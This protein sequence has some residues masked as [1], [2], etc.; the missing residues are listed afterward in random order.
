MVATIFENIY[1]KKPH[2][3]SVPV[4]LERIRNG[5]SRD[6]I[7]AI[8]GTID[9]EKAD[10]LKRLLPSVCFSGKFSK[11]REDESLIAHSGFIVLDFD[12]VSDLREKQ[13]ELINVPYVYACWV[14][15]R[16]NGL[17]ALLK[18]ADGT[19]HRE[20]FAA[21][22][23]LFPDA[24]KSGV[25]LS[26]VCYESYDPEIY[27]N[28]GAE[29]FTA[30][31]EVEQIEVRETIRETRVV[32]D[33]LLKWLANRND[34]FVKGERNLFIFKL[35]SACCRFG[36]HHDDALGMIEGDFTSGS[37]FGRKEVE[38]TVRKAYKSNKAKAGTAMFERD[39]LVEKTTRGEVELDTS[40]YDL[41]VKAQ[42][43][44]LRR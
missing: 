28:E 32:F 15:P 34:A 22:K 40:I 5:N 7:E 27:I 4:L 19:K 6:K 1:S 24:D 17:K 11:E 9:K 38:D 31:K 35:A 37:D 3:K 41:E 18:I 39:M 42:G 20:H 36:I 14:S 8:R 44:D 25:N 23:D 29:T 21:L 30:Y 43:R 12:N 33:N 16:G 13:E 2:Y 26:R 10:A